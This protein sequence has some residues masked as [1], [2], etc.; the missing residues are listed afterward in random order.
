M[1]MWHTEGGKSKYISICGGCVLYNSNQLIHTCLHASPVLCVEV[2]A[3]KTI[4][5]IFYSMIGEKE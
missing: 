5:Q 3:W 4:R 2:I 1:V